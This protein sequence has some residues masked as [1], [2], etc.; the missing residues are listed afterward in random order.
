MNSSCVNSAIEPININPSSYKSLILNDSI[1]KFNK[2]PI[3]DLTDFPVTRNPV[4]QLARYSW[5]LRSISKFWI[6]L[7]F[8]ADLYKEIK[9]S[10]IWV[11]YS[12]LSKADRSPKVPNN[13]KE[14]LVILFWVL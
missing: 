9:Y 10:N 3:S 7:G 6:L 4:K 1:T 8:N 13:K 11:M 2:S 12:L 14:I 5:Y